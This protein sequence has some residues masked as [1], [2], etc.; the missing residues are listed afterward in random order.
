MSG[1]KG[2]ING[3]AYGSGVYLSPQAQTSLGYAK[4][5]QGRS[6]GS[7]FYGSKPAAGGEQT[8]RFM[9]N[10]TNLRVMALCEV[11]KSSHLKKHNAN[12][13]THTNHDE[14][15][16]RMLFVYEDGVASSSIDTTTPAVSEQIRTIIGS[17]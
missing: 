10:S 12:I 8:P 16:T 14:V 13:W 7:S 5:M 3:A 11:V 17:D 1:T 4:I 15:V 2:Q 6:G 9:T